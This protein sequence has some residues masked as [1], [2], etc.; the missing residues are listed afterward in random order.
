MLIFSRDFL[1][2]KRKVH[3]IV[4][5]EYFIGVGW[6]DELILICIEVLF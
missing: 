4:P 2:M 5:V 1:R 6:S 3:E